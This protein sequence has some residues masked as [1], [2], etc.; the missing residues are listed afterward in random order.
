M[1][2]MRIGICDNNIDELNNIKS[3][4]Q[5]L[6]YNNIFSFSSGQALLENNN[7]SLDLLFL[8]IEMDQINGIEFYTKTMFGTC[9]SYVH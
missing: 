3:I 4:C 1:I 7:L 2:T 9:C 8:D 5:N 6:G